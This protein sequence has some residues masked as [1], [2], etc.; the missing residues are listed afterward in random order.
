[1]SDNAAIVLIIG[2]AAVTYIVK[3]VTD[4]WHYREVAKR[5]APAAPD[6]DEGP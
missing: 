5:P 4:A 6:G 1:M 2:I 3:Y